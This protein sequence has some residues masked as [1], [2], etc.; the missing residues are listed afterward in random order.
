MRNEGLV[1]KMHNLIKRKPLISRKYANLM[2]WDFF[3]VHVIR[4]ATVSHESIKMKINVKQ[5]F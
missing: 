3:N 5:K 1:L 4:A 2:L